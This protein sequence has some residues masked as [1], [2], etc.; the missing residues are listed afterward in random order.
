MGQALR[1]SSPNLCLML[2]VLLEPRVQALPLVLLALQMP[3]LLPLE[4]SVLLVYYCDRVSRMVCG[5]CDDRYQSTPQ[6]STEWSICRERERE[7]VQK[8][9]RLL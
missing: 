2:Q 3:V 1:C 4:Q 9:V 6:Q 7:C 8:Y 5:G